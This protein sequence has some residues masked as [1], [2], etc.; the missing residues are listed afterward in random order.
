[1]GRDASRGGRGRL[2]SSTDGV[3]GVRGEQRRLELDA[4]GAGVG[5]SRDF[6]VA[7]LDREPDRLLGRAAVVEYGAEE[8]LA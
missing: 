8:Y 3:I 4:Q 5:L 7:P 2:H 1:M 6:G